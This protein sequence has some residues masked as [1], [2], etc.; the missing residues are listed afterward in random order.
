MRLVLT[1]PIGTDGNTAVRTDEIDLVSRF[2]RRLNE[3]LLVLS[4]VMG[5]FPAENH[6]AQEAIYPLAIC[7][8]TKVA[9]GHGRDTLSLY[10]TG[11]WFTFFRDRNRFRSETSLKAI[12]RSS[13][14]SD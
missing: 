11:N 1:P 7:D 8:I 4:R 10:S 12:R 14:K 3:P 5:P 2:A 6:A 9:H 13:I